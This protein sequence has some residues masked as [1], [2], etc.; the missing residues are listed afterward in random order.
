MPLLV[1]TF[2][3]GVLAGLTRAV[4]GWFFAIALVGAL[5]AAAVSASMRRPRSSFLIY[6]LILTAFLSLGGLRA[7]LGPAR[8]AQAERSRG[9]RQADAVEPVRQRIRD[10]ARTFLPGDQG[11]LML[12]ILLGDTADISSDLTAAFQRT[13]LTHILAVSGMN[14][15]VLVLST[16]FLLGLL[17]A[18]RPFRY[19]GVLVVLI[20]Y[21]ALTGF[22]PSVMRATLM[23][24]VGLGAVAFGRRRDLITALAVAAFLLLMY[25]PQLI[26]MAGFQLSFAATLAIIVLMPV[27]DRLLEIV[28]GKVRNQVNIC[29]AAQLGVVPLLAYHFRQF[30]AVAPLANVLVVPATYP[31]LILGMIMPAAASLSYQLGRLAS[32]VAGPLLAHMIAV[33]RALSNLPVASISLTA[34]SGPLVVGY[35]VVLAGVFWW[36]WHTKKRA[37]LALIAIVALSF[38]VVVVGCEVGQGTPPSRL[39]V[40]FLDV[41]QG[42]ATLI[43]T[44]EGQTLVVDG[45]DTSAG[46]LATIQ[47]L[48]VRKIDLLILSHPHADHVGGLGA[49][50]SSVPVERVLDGGQPHTSRL[51]REL[52]QGIEGK[53][54]RYQR[55]RSGQAFKVGPKLKMELLAPTEPFLSGT[56]S[57]LNNNSVVARVTYG[58]FVVLLVGDIEKPAERRLVASGA[59]LTATVLKVPHHGSS[60]AGDAAFLE[61]VSP[62]VAIISVGEN[63][64]GHPSRTTL[65]RLASVG[66]RVYRTDQRGHVTILS[67]GK[68]YEVETSR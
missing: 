63:D 3:C 42:D 46:A 23:A 37:S 48:G 68:T 17:P 31:V 62:E 60:G 26:R 19:A 33:T 15:A 22:E 16:L 4:P 36:L 57:D 44:P 29:L 10:C 8:P 25:D 43:Q 59:D 67:D 66:A 65:R 56:R 61:A 11:A 41:G 64:F 40:T 52:L 38:A 20:Y 18:A 30:S 21:A 9:Q 47:S 27:L 39:R 45:G 7:S 13:G 34:P 51:Y 1:A 49:I 12:G 6:V 54:I 50:V 53:G 35:Y 2:V 24:T 58:Q 32:E 14:V 55:A 28:P 5:T